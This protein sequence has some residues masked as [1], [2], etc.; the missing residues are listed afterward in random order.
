MKV[1]HTLIFQDDQ[2]RSIN[3]FQVLTIPAFIFESLKVPYLEDHRTDL[4]FC[5]M[6]NHQSKLNYSILKSSILQGS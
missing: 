2:I 4:I 5:L 3:P 6:T 1:Y